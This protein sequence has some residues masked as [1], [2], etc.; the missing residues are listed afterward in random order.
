MALTNPAE[1]QSFPENDPSAKK[2]RFL[3]TNVVEEKFLFTSES[4]SEGHPGDETFNWN[5]DYL[6]FVYLL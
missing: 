5:D 4:V 3:D 6:E 2:A 1:L